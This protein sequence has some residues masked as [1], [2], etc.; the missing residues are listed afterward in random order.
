MQTRLN[1]PSAPSQNPVTTNSYCTDMGDFYRG[2]WRGCEMD[3]VHANGCTLWSA[4][5]M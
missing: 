5:Y 4:G 3:V 2:V 1:T